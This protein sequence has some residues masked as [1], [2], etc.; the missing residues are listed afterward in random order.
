MLKLNN[1]VSL[2]S[3]VLL[4]S[5]VTALRASDRLLPTPKWLPA[6]PGGTFEYQCKGYGGEFYIATVQVRELAHDATSYSMTARVT[7]QN[8]ERRGEETGFELELT[9]KENRLTGTLPF[10]II[11]ADDVLPDVEV[12]D[13][14]RVKIVFLDDS[15]DTGEAKVISTITRVAMDG[16]RWDDAIVVVVGFADNNNRFRFTL[17]PPE[18]LIRASVGTKAYRGGGTME[19]L[20][21]RVPDE[22]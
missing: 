14:M 22:E 20:P 12:G 18:G 1:I 9:Y 3:A 11:T 2:T 6:E 4:L 8:Q 15:V 16:T 5:M 7:L 17:A 21:P 13:V 19:L 10:C